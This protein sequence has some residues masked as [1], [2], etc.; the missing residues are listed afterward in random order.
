MQK[1]K[2]STETQENSGLVLAQFPGEREQR[3]FRLLPPSL[4]FKS[5]AA[6]NVIVTSAQ[7]TIFFVEP[8]LC[9]G[10]GGNQSSLLE[11]L[12]P[13]LKVEEGTS[14]QT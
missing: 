12:P 4:F 6:C 9:A 3:I 1:K 14:L 7:V 2:F 10:T 5:S 11:I 8:K 13:P